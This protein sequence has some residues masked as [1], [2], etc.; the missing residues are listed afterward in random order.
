MSDYNTS[1]VIS[2]E[3]ESNTNTC[4][5]TEGELDTTTDELDV[6]ENEPDIHSCIICTFTTHDVIELYDHVHVI[7]GDIFG[8]IED[9]YINND[10]IECDEDS[11]EECDEEC[12]D[13]IYENS[14]DY[15]CPICERTFPTENHLGEHFSST[16]RTYENQ[17]NLNEPMQETT[18]PGFYI[19]ENINMIYTPSLVVKSQCVKYI[20]KY[21]NKKCLIC[22]EYYSIT[23][24]NDKTHE[25]ININNGEDIDKLCDDIEE[26]KKTE[27]K[28][29]TTYKYPLTLRCCGN[30]ICHDCLKQYLQSNTLN[31][32]LICL[33]CMKDHVQDKTDYIRINE[34]GKFNKKSW[35]MWWKKND[36]ID[37][38]AFK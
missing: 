38:L 22:C 36:R 5:T 34:I 19:L 15:I 32:Q 14:S 24:T 1:Q 37:I 20:K 7:H 9:N 33:F 35:E 29:R 6:T 13:I 16:H 28:P 3:T 11:E 8:S 26:Q 23:T 18:F 31:G 30:E 12:D 17:L 10:E 25:K 4:N 2:D 21:I 27:K